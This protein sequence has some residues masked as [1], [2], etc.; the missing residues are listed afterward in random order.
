M[1]KIFSIVFAL[2]IAGFTTAESV[3]ITAGGITQGDADGRYARLAAANIFTKANTFEGDITIG[4][5][6]GDVVTVNAGTFTFVNPLTYDY[7]ATTTFDGL[8]FTMFM[9]AKSWDFRASSF[10]P[11]IIN[12]TTGPEAVNRNTGDVR[13]PQLAA[14]NTFTKANTFDGNLIFGKLVGNTITYNAG[15]HTYTN[16]LLIDY[17]GFTT[18]DANLNVMTF[19]GL[20]WDFTGT[21]IH[22]AD[23]ASVF[24]AVNLQFGD[25][26]YV[27]QTSV[28]SG[29]VAG[30]SFAGNPKIFT[31]TFGTAFPDTNYSVSVISVESRTWT[32]Q[33]K[34]AGSFVMN[35]NANLAL[36]A[37]VDWIATAHNDP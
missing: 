8:G 32:F 13:W 29:T 25:A 2:G 36:T 9:N 22:V 21:V 18:F 4:D 11:F 19:L 10:A 17:N 20:S 23:P 33:S 28:K 3:L 35:S 34:L 27:A 24:E 31:V 26:R 12:A 37:D 30:A 15:T 5:A 1:R 16:P 7:D 6:V 14:A